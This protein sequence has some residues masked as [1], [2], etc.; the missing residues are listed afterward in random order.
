[1]KE[2]FRPH[3]SHCHDFTA[4]TTP[5]AAIVGVCFAA[6]KV[7]VPGILAQTW[8]SP[9]HVSPVMG[10]TGP[11]ISIAVLLGAL[12]IFYTQRRDGGAGPSVTNANPFFYAC[13]AMSL[14]SG[15]MV[16]NI[17][18]P[19]KDLPGLSSA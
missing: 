9:A 1:M 17:P 12:A 15:L 3:G 2:R 13:C 16:S 8:G 19:S 18:K 10:L 6:V 7:S 11:A 4:R 14:V 5:F